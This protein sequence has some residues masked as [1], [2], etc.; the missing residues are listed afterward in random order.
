MVAQGSKARSDFDWQRRINIGFSNDAAND[1]FDGLIDDVA[2]WSVALSAQQV[3]A[4]ASGASPLT[5]ASISRFVD[6]DVESQLRS[7]SPSLLLRVPFEVS[8][9]LGEETLQLRVRYDDGY[10]AYLNGVEI[11][12]R[13]APENVRHDSTALSDRSIAAAASFEDVA[14][15]GGDELLQIGQNV[16]AIHAL[17]EH[18]NSEEFLI[19]PELVRVERV[20]H[21]YFQDPTAGEPNYS[22]GIEGFVADTTFSVDR[23][24]YT[25]PIEV[26]ITSE[27][28][29]A[30]IRYTL[31][32][33]NPTPTSGTVYSAPIQIDGTT[34]LRAAAF[35][36]GLGA[37]NVD[38]H[39]YIFPED[40]VEQSV[41]LPDITNH[42]TYGPLLVPA[43]SMIPSVSIVT[44]TPVST[45]SEVEASIELILPNGSQ[46]FQ[47]H[48]GI[49]RVGGHSI[50]FPK[51]NM[52]LYFRRQYGPGRL[53]YPLFR[54]GLYAEGAAEEFDQ[55]DL[56]GGSHDSVFYLGAN[57]QLPSNAQYIRNRWMS[58]TLHEM[59]QIS[60]HGRYVQVYLN[61]TYWGHY[62]MQ[63][64]PTRAH[65]ASYQ[66]GEEDEF[67][68]VNSGRPVG[69]SSPAWS[70]IATIRSDYDEVKR[71]VDVESLVD[72]MLLNFYAGNAWDWRSTQNWMAAGPSSPDRGG[73]RF[74]SWDA[75][76]TLRRTNDYNLDQPGPGNLFRDLLQHAEFRRL[77]GDRIH[78]HFYNDGILTPSEVDRMFRRR[79]IEVF[80]TIVAETARWRWG[81]IVWTRGNQWEQEFARL[82]GD[83][84]PQRTE[85]VLD[86]IAGTN[87]YPEVPAPAFLIDDRR[88][89][90]GAIT[91]GAQLSIVVPDFERYVE[92]TLV[93]HDSPVSAYV[94]GSGVLGTDWRLGTYEEGSNGETWSTGTGGVGYEH[95]SG[96]EDLIGIDV[97]GEM[98][99]G[100]GN[101]S[102]YVRVTFTVDETTDLDTFGDLVLKVD[103]DDGF[104]A[105]LNGV[106]V[107]SSNAPAEV[108]LDW[109]SAATGSH[110][111]TPASPDLFTINDFR[112]ALTVGDNTLAIH[113]LNVNL[114]SSDMIIRVELFG[115]TLETEAAPG[116]IKYT[117]DGSDPSEPGALDFTGPLTIAES[118]ILK[119]RAFDENEWSALSEAL[120]VVPGSFPL[121]V[122]EV[123]YHP[124][125][126]PAG[127][128]FDDDDFEF[129]ELR[130]ID[131]ETL[132]LEGV[133]VRGGICFEFS[134]SDVQSLQPG[135]HVLLVNNL[136]AFAAIYDAD[137]MLIAG[138]YDGRLSNGG[139]YVFISGPLGET[140]L[141]VSYDDA[142]YPSTDGGGHSLVITDD[143]APVASWSIAE[144]WQPSEEFGGSPGFSEDELSL[145]GFRLPGDANQDG[146]LDISDPVRLLRILF[147]GVAAPCDEAGRAKL[148]DINGDA[149]VDLTDAIAILS[150]LYQ[151]GP[152]PASGSRC[153]RIEGCEQ[154]CRL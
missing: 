118:T 47:V 87:W 1:Y 20:D 139:E 96:Y 8:D 71:W 144:S 136:D 88:Q 80:P 45:T 39:T 42:E 68:A 150:Y 120:F 26:E 50:G 17:N 66:G 107:A 85:I 64:R 4:L 32:S 56:R 146:R 22:D 82:T 58:D 72:Y 130:N 137:S 134:T 154:S 7:V 99:N 49:K 126:P 108:E 89:H 111:A 65:A 119:A 29:D 70:H 52:R 122:T 149:S 48:A 141:D 121:R 142:W 38:T 46:G 51:N 86:Q 30:T 145:G 3:Q 92:T 148:L 94:P 103:Y 18:E 36:D 117:I 138:E 53:D 98:T 27:T 33:S 128:P 135:E 34:V 5:G 9:S 106:R 35:R 77:V 124:A 25:A 76:I 115:R 104:V 55:L 44:T 43:L 23:G 123:M 75:D 143:N 91:Q 81:G 6:T 16:L 31:D 79:A 100:P 11:A 69:S 63:E 132:F 73:Y 93:P 10:V 101:T 78:R 109:N 114:T 62:Q 113:G 151:S 127:S 90:G 83:F 140:V 13:S 61:G 60:N 125:N 152:M 153:V 12:R 84:F 97:G 15:A 74:Y 37:T 24:V 41:M 110:E 95:S 147:H 40:V 19:A 105:Y 14:V 67:E 54:D 116:A 131:S 21:R 102:V 129:F 59:G 112:E 133:Q 28:V 57:Q 2:I